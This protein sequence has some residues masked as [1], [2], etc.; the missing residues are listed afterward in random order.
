MD[1]N[2]A[3]ILPLLFVLWTGCGS[4][5]TQ[6]PAD[7]RVDAASPDAAPPADLAP[8]S[9]PPADAQAP[10]V[11]VAPRLKAGAASVDV[12]PTQKGVPLGGFGGEP[13]RK[14]TLLNIPAHLSAA[15]GNCYDPAPGD[16]ASLFEP[17]QGKHDPITAKALV[18]DNGQTKAAVVKIDAIG[19]DRTMRDELEQAAKGLGIPAENLI[20]TATHT[21]SGPG[22]VTHHK[23]FAL[24][25][26]DCLHDPTYQAMLAGVKQALT[27]ADAALQPARIGIGSVQELSVSKNRMGRPGVFDPTLGLIKVVASK[28]DKPIAA[29]M[30]FAVHGTCLGASNMQFSADLMGYA[31]RDLEKKLGGGVALFV[32]GTEGD[33]APSQGGLTGAAALGGI[34]A[35]STGKLWQTLATKP[36]IEIQGKLE[37]VQ[38]P[39]ASVKGCLELFGAGKTLC[40]YIP[41]LKLPLDGFMQ[42]E[43]PFGAL[44]LDDVVIA[45]IPGEAI[46]DIGQEIKKAGKAD[47]FRLTLLFGLA[48]DHMGYVVTKD[49]YAT[50]GY[51]P[52]STMYGESTGT[53]VVN[54]ATKVIGAVKPAAP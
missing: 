9:T 27:Q 16:A 12:T 45:T 14:F 33:V 36:W 2:R 11:A 22:A 38:M 3:W 6:P 24:V 43:L 37:D 23:L 10:D 46:T 35:D 18:L 54:A 15:L 52:N 41:G 13:R 21:H 20:V 19:I 32:N 4:E 47:G 50:D 40:D 34:L 51:E 8:D 17:S 25:A 48:N 29:L 53:I 7:S 42:K 5:G 49:L 39:K 1:G 31:E 26:M 44:R 28:A 30:N